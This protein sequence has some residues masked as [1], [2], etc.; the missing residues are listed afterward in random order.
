MTWGD[1]T[2]IAS[3]GSAIYTPPG[4]GHRVEA[5][6]E[7]PF[8]ALV[9]WWAPGGDKEAIGRNYRFLGD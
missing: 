2:F 5:I 9:F 7:E 1:D 6:G 8:V 4:V 3:S